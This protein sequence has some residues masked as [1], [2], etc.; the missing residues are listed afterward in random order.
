MKERAPFALTLDTFRRYGGRLDWMM[1]HTTAGCAN[2]GHYDRSYTKKKR[3][4]RMNEKTYV[5]LEAA[6]VILLQ[7]K[8]GKIEG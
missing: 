6:S 1:I 5:E 3:K 8:V 4:K 7:D 2:V